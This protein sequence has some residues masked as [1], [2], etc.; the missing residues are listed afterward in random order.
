MDMDMDMD[1]ERGER[2]GGRAE[3]RESFTEILV[4]LN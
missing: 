2:D 1:M 3:K 4:V